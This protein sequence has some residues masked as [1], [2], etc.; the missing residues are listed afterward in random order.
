MIKK[1]LLLLMAAGLFCCTPGITR[2][3]YQVPAQIQQT[4]CEV[5]FVKNGGGANPAH[6]LGT[7][8][9]H[10]GIFSH[11]FSEQQAIVL[12]R[13]EACL[14]GANQVAFSVFAE[15]SFFCRNCY[16]LYAD[17]YQEK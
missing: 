11:G 13:N 12:V 10:K 4:E 6:K 14:V 5:F 9:I 3:G 16:K 2:I 17:L 15:K 8:I 1:L 7:I